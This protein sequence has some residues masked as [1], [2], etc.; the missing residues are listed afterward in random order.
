[1]P[2]TWRARRT[3]ARVVQVLCVALSLSCVGEVLPASATT[4][5][6]S[7]GNVSATLN[8]QKVYPSG[9]NVGV[10]EARNA[11]LSIKVAE[12]LAYRAA[13]YSPV[14]ARLCVPVAGNASGRGNALRVLRLR[15]GSPDVLLGLYSGGAHCCFIDQVFS[16]GPGNLYVKTEIDLGDPGARVVTLPGS[17]YAALVT[18]DDTFA[19]AFT[20]FAASGLPLKIERLSGHR[21]IDVTR[22]Y[23]YL[24]RA[25]ASQWLKA[26][27][28]QRSSRYQ[29][30]VGVIAAWTAD[31]FLLGRS[32]SAIRFLHQ[33]AGAGH[34]NSLLNPAA[35]GSTFVTLLQGF[36][37]RE[38]Y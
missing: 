30:S 25:D 32:L 27:Y 7:Q 14:C 24:V 35:R 16:P 4:D 2:A 1:M 38:G 37:R 11:V 31:E 22:H 34:L 26:F 5:V 12:H 13:L 6:A 36:L 28:A 23:P 20:D 17:P 18:A 19:Y 9:G 29:D 3:I 10:P 8:Y 33:Q 21:F 15:P